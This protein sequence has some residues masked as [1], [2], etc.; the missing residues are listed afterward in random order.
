MEQ[1]IC[2]YEKE[3]SETY[4]SPVR[5]LFCSTFFRKC[6][7]VLLEC[8]SERFIAKAGSVKTTLQPRDAIPIPSSPVPDPSSK[9]LILLTFSTC[10][11]RFLS[12]IGSTISEKCVSKGIE[13]DHTVLSTIKDF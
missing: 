3:H 13:D 4:L 2:V 8:S 5:S 9:T 1:V 7:I 6:S 11:P 10:N 12:K